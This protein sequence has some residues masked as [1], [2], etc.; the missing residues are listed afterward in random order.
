MRGFL[1]SLLIAATVATLAACDSGGD[2]GK[3][4]KSAPHSTVTQRAASVPVPKGIPDTR[5]VESSGRFAA[6]AVEKGAGREVQAGQPV[7]IGARCK[8]G[9]C[10]I[11]YRVEAK[12]RGQILQVQQDILRRLFAR[13]STRSVVLYVHHQQ[14]GS[15]DKNEAPA[16]ATATCHRGRPETGWTS[17]RFGQVQ[18]FCRFTHVAAGL[19]RNLVRRGLLTNK[20]ASKGRAAPGGGPPPK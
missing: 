18:V 1:S 14:V 5:R 11:R 15:P 3:K 16:F 4:M 17:L 6:A 10:V 19:Q 9:N 13:P 2:S 12:G 7:V 8:A 20:Q